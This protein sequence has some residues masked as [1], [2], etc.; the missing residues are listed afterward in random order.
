MIGFLVAAGILLIVLGVWG[1]PRRRQRQEKSTR[2]PKEA[3][4]Q[5]A[6]DILTSP[7]E[8]EAEIIKIPE[9]KP[10]FVPSKDRRFQRGLLVG[11]GLG[12]GVAALVAPLLPR[13]AAPQGEVA[14]TPPPAAEPGK[15][16]TT[17]P[18]P[19]TTEPPAQPPQPAPKP[20]NQTFVVEP[21]SPSQ[22]IAASLKAAGLIADEQ[23]FLDRIAALG[24][25]T[26]LKAGT[27]VIPTGA[28]LDDV[29]N[30]LTR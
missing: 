21:G 4:V 6:W 18:A 16:G 14:S 1:G 9:H 2:I 10:W 28:S 13:T 25:E 30:E 3:T 5:E 15:T 11:L 26:Q 7:V 29:I 12:L 20:A 8:Y 17:T 24:V 19:S 22:S 27:F 23:A